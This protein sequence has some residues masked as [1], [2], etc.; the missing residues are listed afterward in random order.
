MHSLIYHQTTEECLTDAD[1]LTESKVE[2]E[3]QT[4]EIKVLYYCD[5]FL[6]G[7]FESVY[8]YFFPFF[9]LGLPLSRVIAS[10]IVYD[11]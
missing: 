10:G 11:V 2:Y 5:C 7:T 1:N 3:E 8:F 4:T 9:Y 6:W